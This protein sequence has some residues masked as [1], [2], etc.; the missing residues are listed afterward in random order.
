[1]LN[2]LKIET[3][4]RSPGIRDLQQSEIV[5]LYKTGGNELIDS[6]IFT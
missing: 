5:S 2:V 3:L 6:E 1:M 4:R